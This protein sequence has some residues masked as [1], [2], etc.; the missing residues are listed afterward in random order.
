MKRLLL[1]TAMTLSLLVGCAEPQSNTLPSAIEKQMEEQ[2]GM[3]IAV[4]SND[5]LVVKYAEIRYPPIVNGQQIA[6][7]SI[8][9]IVYTDEKGEL[10]PITDEQKAEMRN[11]QQREIFYGEYAGRP[12][13]IME[14]ST[15]KNSLHDAKT[16]EIEG[17][18][19]EYGQKEAA[20]GTYAF[21]SFHHQNASYMTTFLLNDTTTTD[22]AVAFNRKLIRQL[23]GKQ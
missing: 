23:Q 20:S 6:G 12:I 15:M 19:V 11:R 13:V 14:I 17:I 3:D 16:A 7:P 8:A 21:Y 18:T 2:I 10:L 1:C 9:T 5:K 4:P 22:D